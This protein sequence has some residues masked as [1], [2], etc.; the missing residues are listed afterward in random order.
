V[1]DY[2]LEVEQVDEEANTANNVAPVSVE[3][4]RDKLRVLLCDG[5]SQ[6]EYRYLEQLFRRDRHIEFDELLFYPRVR[7]TGEMAL[8]PRLPERVDDWAVYDVVILGDVGARQFSTKSQ[9]TLVDYVRRRQGRL[10]VIA[11]RDHMPQEYVDQPLMD[12]LPVERHEDVSLAEP[13]GVALSDEGRLHS[14]LAIEDSAQSS[15]LSWQ[16]TYL[17]QPLH[18]LSEYSRPKETARTLIYA[19]PVQEIDGVDLRESLAGK[20]A[21]LCWQRVGSGRVVYLSSPQTYLL[22]FRRGDR[23]HHR[24]W[25]QMIRWI[26]AEQS[27]SGSETVRLTTDQNR[28]QINEPIEITVWLKDQTGRPSS[29]QSLNVVVH[30][31][32][33][34]VANVALEP[35]REVAGRYFARLEAIA[36]GTFEII[37]QGAAVADLAATD[38]GQAQVRTLVTVESGDDLEMLDTSTNRALLEQVAETTGGQVTPPT[39]MAE[40]IEL[41]SLSPEVSETVQSTPLWNR[42]TNLWI[43]VGCLSL[44]WAVRKHKGLV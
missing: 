41:A 12:L 16:N 24:F 42:W 15:E 13:H 34:E 6:W 39:A 31:L 19:V 25:G 44:E 32:D 3:V 36:P 18:G 20:P 10:I 8:R 1:Q 30:T 28:Y 29:N 33:K 40:V 21:F 37:V 38:Q 35:D 23:L 27:G 14:A 43:V 4:V 9:Q 17:R 26:T 2:E 7:G 22:R 5:I 11:G